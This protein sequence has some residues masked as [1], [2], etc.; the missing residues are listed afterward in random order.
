[1]SVFKRDGFY[2]FRFMHRGR[3]VRKSTKQRNERVAIAMEAAERTAKSKG[4]AGLG[5]KPVLPT[6]ERFLLDRV[7]PW[8]LKLK[9]ATKATWFHS[10]I[11]PITGH[12]PLARMRLDEITSEHIDAYTAHRLT[13]SE[14]KK[15]KAVGTVNRELRV[16]RRSLRL[17][18]KWRVLPKEKLP[19]V[20]MSRRG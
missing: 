18:V 20:S 3:V 12:K 8:S 6:L 15:A 16:L 11:K 1:M 10:G 17:A 13:A 7:T 4:D 5:E 2:H 14:T 19:E 9:K